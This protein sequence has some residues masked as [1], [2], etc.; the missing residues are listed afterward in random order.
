MLC[1]SPLKALINDQY[2]RLLD[3]C[4]HADTDAHRWHGD[5]PATAKKRVLAKPSGVLLITPESL[6][7]MFVMRGT[8]MRTLFGNLAFVVIDEMHAFL[9]TA[10]GAQIQ[11]LMNRIELTIRRRP[12]RIGLSA[13]LG[14]MSQAAWF[15]RPNN[16]DGVVLIN[17]DAKGAGLRMQ[18]RGYKEPPPLKGKRPPDPMDSMAK[19]EIADHLY[20]HLRGKGNLIFANARRDVELYADLLA[21][22]S[23][24]QR[25]PNEFWPHHGSLSKNMR[26]TVER[27]LKDT[28]R[29]ASAICTSTL[30]MGIDIGA[31]SSVAQVGP[32]P[33]VASLRQR[34]GRSGRRGD[35]SVLRIYITE[36]HP[37]DRFGLM[38]ELR[39]S[40]VRTTAM[41]RL[42]L[43]KWLEAPDDPGYNYSTLVQQ[44]LSAVAQHG[45]ATAVDL[46]RG[47]CGP[48]PFHLVDKGRFVQL[49]RAMIARDLIFQNSEG[50]LLHG[51]VGERHVNHYAFYAAFASA[52]E[53]RL[54]VKGR[55]LGTIPLDQPI[56]K[57][58]RLI[59][60][61]KRW[62]VNSVDTDTRVVDVEPSTGGNPPIFSGS[63]ALVSDR[64]RTEMVE[65]YKGSDVPRWLD[66]TARDL[67]GEGRDT[68]AR[69]G[70]E[71]ESVVV[72]GDAVLL[73][74][75]VGDRALFTLS[76]MLRGVG[77]ACDVEGP[78]VMVTNAGRGS[79][80]SALGDILRQPPPE[81]QH[82]TEFIENRE[83][84]KWDWALTEELA[85]E[86]AGAR[87]LDIPKAWAAIQEMVG[88]LQ[89]G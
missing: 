42:M 34:L 16:P 76:M 85:E 67:L 48:G 56:H 17:S 40:L 4:E 58:M 37:D 74:P 33:S 24:A 46:Y 41:V 70:L 10:R 64:V 11:S 72:E 75:W 57:G 32:P 43:D 86:S 51:E 68:F 52:E 89:A 3:M 35:P 26:E 65:V 81:A 39:C 27:E 87:L 84:D 29:P 25:V 50:L 5:V 28:S 45:G 61:G 54:T 23:E 1:L 19:N 69:Y 31:I 77:F 2:R 21:G 66:S 73:F 7:A 62:L 12:P 60:G 80:L 83:I 55:N 20:A 59:F 47:L 15:L 9:S 88:R 79:I 8:R 38:D 6:E 30:E 78:S 13:T 14:D 36:K 71:G 22:R 82:L 18:L 49:L 63:P 53:W 44:V